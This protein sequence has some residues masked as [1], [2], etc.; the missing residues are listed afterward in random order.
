MYE[1][2]VRFINKINVF[3][4]DENLSHYFIT[5]YSGDISTSTEKIPVTKI[6]KGRFKLIEQYEKV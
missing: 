3:L 2:Q 6:L 1:T 5:F 4:Q